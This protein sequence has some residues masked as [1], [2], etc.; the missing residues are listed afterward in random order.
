[1]KFLLF[2]EFT[3]FFLLNQRYRR[4]W[5]YGLICPGVSGEKSIPKWWA[6][7]KKAK[8]P[9]WKCLGPAARLWLMLIFFSFFTFFLHFHLVL[10]FV[11]V[12]VCLLKFMESFVGSCSR[13][14]KRNS[15]KHYIYSLLLLEPTITLFTAIKCTYIF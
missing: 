11:C 5:L 12:C 7:P 15:K 2:F 4:I 1:M 9:K 8:I 10:V 13:Y 14:Y 6:R 3:I